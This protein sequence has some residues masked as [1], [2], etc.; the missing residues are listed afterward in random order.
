MSG[1]ISDVADRSA[2]PAPVLTSGPVTG[3]VRAAGGRHGPRAVTAVTRLRAVLAVA[4]VAASL[5]ACN[6]TDVINSTR[7]KTYQCIIDFTEGAPRLSTIRFGKEVQCPVQLYI[8]DYVRYTAT[9]E[10]DRS[11]SLQVPY[12][13]VQFRNGVGGYVGAQFYEQSWRDSSASGTYLQIVQLN[14]R[15]MAASAWN[16]G[17]FDPGTDTAIFRF[18]KVDGSRFTARSA[19]AYRQGEPLRVQSSGIAYPYSTF[20]VSSELLDPRLDGPLNYVWT[21][22]GSVV[23]TDRTLVRSSGGPGDSHDIQLTVSDASGVSVSASTYVQ[24]KTCDYEGCADM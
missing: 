21:D 9:A 7:V 17:N 22:N 15:Y 10:F 1:A 5:A 6:V 12:V 24:V 13:E 3:S 14:G 20:T 18:Q 2:A 23:S 8:S 11:V 16:S 19:L 4:L